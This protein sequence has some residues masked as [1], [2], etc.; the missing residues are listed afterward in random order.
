MKMNSY[1]LSAD[2]TFALYYIWNTYVHYCNRV[3]S[4]RKTAS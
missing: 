3:I 2:K 1:V 4:T